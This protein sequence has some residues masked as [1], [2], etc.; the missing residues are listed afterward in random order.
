MSE[1][2][3]LISECPSCQTRFRV[4]AEQLAVADGRVRCGACLAV[5]DG[6]E[7]QVREEQT[8]VGDDP[9]DVLLE[10]A[11][12]MELPGTGSSEEDLRAPTWEH[13]EESGSGTT[14]DRPKHTLFFATAIAA[15]LALLA[16]GILVLQYEV[17]VQDPVLREAY[18]IVGVELPRYKALD[19][20]DIANPSVDERLG[21]PAH[22]IVRLDL[23]N[24]ATRYQRFPTLVVQF[25]REDGLLLAEPQ[26]VEPAAYLPS[27]TQSR[28]MSPRETTSVA[29]RLDDPGPAALGYTISLL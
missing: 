12:T 27:P 18:E 23:T 29:L 21:A 1:S 5:F 28:R 6:R 9:V 8:V 25:H 11:A 15:A 2:Q 20:I 3:S 10:S 19:E 16:A 14:A 13:G 17:Y 26:R 4:T 24:T 7:A 22:L